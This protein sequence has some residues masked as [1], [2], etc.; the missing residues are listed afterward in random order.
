MDQDRQIRFAI[1]PFFFLASL[2]LG[3]YFS[4]RPPDLSFLLK[5]ETTKELFGLFAATAVLI[6]PVGFFISASSILILRLLALA[7]NFLTKGEWPTYE[8]HLSEGTLGRI[9]DRINFIAVH[10][11]NVTKTLTLYAAVTF[12][13]SMLPEG[14]HTWLL[15]RWN[16]FNVCCHSIVA[17]GLAH[18]VA[19]W[20]HPRKGT[21][22][23]IE[24][25]LCWTLSTAI[26]IFVLAFNAVCAYRETMAMATFQSRIDQKKA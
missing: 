1:P 9:W 12:D 19:P 6:L 10:R 2:L 25:T 22:W 16:L 20:F 18:L 5:P 21:E 15:R 8:A 14:I 7:L 4:P 3:A 26:I 24:N 23:Q 13:H 11:G 17:I